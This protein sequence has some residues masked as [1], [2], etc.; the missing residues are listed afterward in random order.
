MKWLLEFF[1]RRWKQVLDPNLAMSYKA[2]FMSIDGQKVLQHLLDTE[3]FQVYHGTDPYQA[4]AFNA[5]RAVI[6]EI[7][8]NIDVAENPQKYFAPPDV[9]RDP[10]EES[11]NAP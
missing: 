9:N 4:V 3:Y 2:T 5:R 8:V 10:R 11:Q 6:H 7:L 1:A